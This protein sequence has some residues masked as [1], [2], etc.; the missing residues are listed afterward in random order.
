MKKRFWIIFGASILLRLFVIA[1]IGLGDDEVYHWVWAQHLSLSYYDHPPLVTYIIWFLTKLFGDT[2][3]V[4]HLEALCSV[5][6]FTLI[7]YF[8]A[9]EIYSEKEAIM[10]TLLIIFVPIFFVGGVIVAPDSPLSV[11]WVLT[12]YLVYRALRENKNLYWY[13][14]GITAGFACLSKYNGFFLPFLILLYLIFS[15]QHRFWLRKKEP[16]LAFL[17][18]L[19][20]L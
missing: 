7:L 18:M 13:T 19:V 2:A 3:F 12:L 4:V 17:L 5:I 16:Y 20:C 9:K 15:P 14:A 8:W 1:K 11:F 10:G 6:L